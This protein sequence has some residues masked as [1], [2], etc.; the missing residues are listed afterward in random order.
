MD[1]GNFLDEVRKPV[2]F[3]VFK[4]KARKPSPLSSD[5]LYILQELETSP[6]LGFV[7]RNGL[8]RGKRRPIMIRST[9]LS[10]ACAGLLLASALA[11]AQ[12]YTNAF[13]GA[14]SFARP[15]WMEEIPGKPGNLLVMEQGG[16]TQVVTKTGDTWTKTQFGRI[17][18][19][20][21][22]SGGNEQGLLGFAFHPKYAQ[23]RKYYLYYVGGGG[24]QNIIEERLADET[25]LKDAGGAGKTILSIADYA[26][27]HNGGTIR[28]GSD[29]FL[30]L[31]TGD[32]GDQEDPRGNGQN[33]NALLAKVL[34][35]D[36]DN[37]SGGK[38]YGI[39]SDNPYA[40]SGGLPE[41]YAIGF[42]NPYKW[43]FDPVT[44][45]M[46]V[47][48]VGQ[49]YAEEVNLVVKG[50]NYGWKV[51]EGDRGVPA[52]GIIAPVAWYGRGAGQCIIG[53]YVFRG[54]P[55]SRFIAHFI[56]GDYNTSNMWAAKS[57]GT[58]PATVVSLAKPPA[59][60]RGFGTDNAGRIYIMAGTTTIYALTG[61]D[62]NVATSNFIP[63]EGALKQSIGCIFA[64]RPGS[65]LDAKAFGNAKSVEIFSLSGEKLGNLGR[66]AEVP[67]M[68]LGMYIVK[69]PGAKPNMMMVK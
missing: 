6:I 22:T 38:N 62:W 10:R 37:P 35:I 4:E 59:E 36:V 67:A 65:R 32:G 13:P 33:K 18:V 19:T 55:A 27:N 16:A 66:D 41:I 40:T 39:P 49:G 51:Q 24:G 3:A 56:Y 23:N 29:N 47:A 25:L 7:G 45:E 26:G 1:N 20:G 60:P 34:R 15:L 9:T 54:N 28:F 17:T 43:A 57:N 14:G 42:R 53:G 44:K 52:A 2:N 63:K 69:A 50:G 12:T 8:R 48:D 64:C 5:L 58:S 31:A 30:Y 68:K 46:W 61:A 11:G 21:G